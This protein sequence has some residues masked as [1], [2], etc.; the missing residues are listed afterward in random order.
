MITTQATTTW[1]FLHDEGETAYT[2]RGRQ[3]IRVESNGTRFTWTVRVR[4]S[5]GAMT[6]VV[7][8]GMARTQQGAMKDAEEWAESNI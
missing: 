5:S 3:V 4:L 6:G 2:V 7:G 1:R 8:G